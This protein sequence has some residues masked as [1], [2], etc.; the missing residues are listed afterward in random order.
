VALGYFMA[1]GNELYGTE[2][3]LEFARKK[4]AM[5]QLFNNQPELFLCGTLD[6]CACEICREGDDDQTAPAAS[7]CAIVF[8]CDIAS[9]CSVERFITRHRCVPSALPSAGL[10]R[11]FHVA[12]SHCSLVWEILI[13]RP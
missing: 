9:I 11:I 6:L 3:H 5:Q 4:H 7:A 10:L 13:S 1:L 2:M 12:G 8:D